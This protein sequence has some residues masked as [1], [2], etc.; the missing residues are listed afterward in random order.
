[1]NVSR[2]E[3]VAVGA[4]KDSKGIVGSGFVDWWTEN[5]HSLLFIPLKAWGWLLCFA[6]IFGGLW[7]AVSELGWL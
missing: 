2:V 4:A 1:L 7:L 3:V 6:S 5:E